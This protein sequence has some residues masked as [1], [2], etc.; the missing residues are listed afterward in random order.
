MNYCPLNASQYGP[1]S[2]RERHC[3]LSDANGNCLV[4]RYL[5]VSIEEKEFMLA[6]KQRELEEQKEKVLNATKV[7]NQF[8]TQNEINNQILNSAFPCGN[9]QTDIN[10]YANCALE[11]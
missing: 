3:T 4:K 5:E 8:L 11:D 1:Q 2:C 6:A 7:L 10:R 9:N